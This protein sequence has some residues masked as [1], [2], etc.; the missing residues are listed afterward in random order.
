MKHK[1]VA[2]LAELDPYRKEWENLRLDCR[3]S[4]FTSFDLVRIWLEAFKGTA[5]PQVVM[6]EDH[7]ALV[8]I[9]PMCMQRQSMAGLPVRNLNMV[10]FGKEILGYSLM[11]VMAKDADDAVLEELVRGVGRVKWNLMQLIALDPTPSTERFLQLIK[12][13]FSWQPFPEVSNLFYEFPVEGE[14]ASKFGSN[15]R[16]LL[17]R[18]RNDLQREG[19]LQVRLAK[20]GAEAERAMCLYVEQHME[21]WRGKGGSIFSDQRNAHQLVEMGKYVVENGAGLI[22]EMLIDNEVAAQSLVLLDGDVARGYRVGMIDRFKD[23]SP[24]KLIIMLVMEDLRARGLKG[25]DLLRGDEDYKHHM[26]TRERM[27]PAIQVLRGSLMMMSKARKLPGIHQLDERLG[28]G[29]RVLKR[30]NEG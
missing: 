13:E 9:A 18:I 27:L 10:G 17:R 1:I 21:R 25:Y 16:R 12:Q 8:G 22:H 26:K 11:S 15:S 28:V 6:V 30:A 19:R 4:I 23:Y 14:I 7:G 3:S 24:G 20:N 2:S 5:Q 29:D